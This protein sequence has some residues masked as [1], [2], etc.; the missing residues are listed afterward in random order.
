[1]SDLRF[2]IRQLLKNPGWTAVAVVTLALGIGANTAVFSMVNRV[3]LL[4][5]PFKDPDRLVWV[6]AQDPKQN[7]IDNMAAGP[8]YLAWRRDSTSFEHLCALGLMEEFNLH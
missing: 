1:M 4:P 8:D 5:L 6:A 2:A 7:F 3:L